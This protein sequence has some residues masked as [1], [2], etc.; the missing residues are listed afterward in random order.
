MLPFFA[1]AKVNGPHLMK[2]LLKVVHNPT[3]QLLLVPLDGSLKKKNK[4]I[5]IQL[6]LL[7]TENFAISDWI[8]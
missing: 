7:S 3:T 8:Q 6:C 4:E 5:T 1:T 2:T